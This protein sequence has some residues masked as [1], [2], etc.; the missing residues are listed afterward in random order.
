MSNTRPPQ[1][2]HLPIGSCFSTSN[3]EP[4][5]VHRGVIEDELGLVGIVQ[6]ERGGKRTAQ[7]AA[8]TLKRTDEAF[9][10][11]FLG[12]ERLEQTSGDDLAQGDRFVLGL[13]IAQCLHHRLAVR[14]V[15][16]ERFGGD[17]GL[18]KIL[19]FLNDRLGQ[20]DRSPP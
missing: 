17:A 14:R 3:F 15:E 4:V 16:P 11:E 2:G 8:E 6:L 5:S 20:A 18:I 19:G 13:V 10:E 12:F 7:T 9:L 1:I